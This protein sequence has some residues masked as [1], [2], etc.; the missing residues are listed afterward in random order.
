MNTYIL[1]LQLIINKYYPYSP[2]SLMDLTVYI[3]VNYMYFISINYYLL[4]RNINLS[5]TNIYVVYNM[6][7]II[8]LIITLPYQQAHH[9]TAFTVM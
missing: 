7:Y 1:Q 8:P 5:K 3:I 9:Q 6:Q 4:F 2:M